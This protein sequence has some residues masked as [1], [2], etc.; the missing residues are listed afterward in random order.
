VHRGSRDAVEL[1]QGLKALE[2]QLAAV[3]WFPGSDVK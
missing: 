1:G 2:S 3:T